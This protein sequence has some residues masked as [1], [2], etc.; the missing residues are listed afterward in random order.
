MS[1]SFRCSRRHERMWLIIGM[2]AVAGWLLLLLINFLTF[3][4]LFDEKGA[5]NGGLVDTEGLTSG[6]AHEAHV[7]SNGFLAFG[8]INISNAF[9]IFILVLLVIG[10]IVL[11]SFLKTGE[12]YN[13]SANET[14]FTIT[15]PDGKKDTIVY[16]EVLAVNGE[17]RRFPFAAKGL[18]ITVYTKNGSFGYRFIHTPMSRSAGIAETPF[19][20]IMERSELAQKPYFLQKEAY[21]DHDTWR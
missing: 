13:F 7:L 4:G 15:H 5:L 17:E 3:L 21:R 20:M 19:H 10:F 9:G 12:K 11:F 6:N 16:S 2:A 14:E 18:D 1:G 8:A